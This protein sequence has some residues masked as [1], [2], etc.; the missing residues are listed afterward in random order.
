M[1]NFEFQLDQRLAQDSEWLL[2]SK[3]SQWRVM[4]DSRYYWLLQIPLAHNCRELYQLP[5][6]QLAEVQQES[7]IVS[8]ILMQQTAADKLN[9][10]ALG[11]IVPQLHIHHIARNQGDPAWPAPVWGHAAAQPFAADALQ[12][13]LAQLRQWLTPAI[14]LESGG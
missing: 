3:S 14:A 9:V 13:R 4:N 6:Q 12:Q 8:E 7:L 5:A 11:N 10:A 1:T 2:N